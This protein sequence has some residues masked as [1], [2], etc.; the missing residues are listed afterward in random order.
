M[1]QVGDA[2]AIVGHNFGV[3][4]LPTAQPEIATPLGRQVS[5]D[6]RYFLGC[7]RVT[8][9]CWAAHVWRIHRRRYL[10]LRCQALIQNRPKIN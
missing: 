10:F 4:R 5:V 2:F 7:R 3:E 9:Y 8:P 6:I 1:A